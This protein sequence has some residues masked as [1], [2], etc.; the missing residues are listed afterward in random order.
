V[1]AKN[2][3]DTI[4]IASVDEY[5]TLD[6]ITEQMDQQLA[7][8]KIVGN[9]S[10]SCFITLRYFYFNYFNTDETKQVANGQILRYGENPHQK[11]LFLR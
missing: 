6:L 10:V 9:K 8:R 11:R 7:D 5:T 1:R 3:K 2:F 4:I